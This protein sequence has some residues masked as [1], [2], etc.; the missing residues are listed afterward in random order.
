MWTFEYEHPTTAAREAVWALWSDV[1]RWPEWDDDLD[2]VSL[3]GDFSA[4]TSGT[5]T[6]KGIGPLEFTITAAEPGR[7][8]SD[9][10]LLPG[11]VLRFEH[12]LLPAE[13]GTVIRQRVT[14]DGPSANDYFAELGP[15]IILDV[16]TALAR[17]ADRAGAERAERARP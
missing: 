1:A 12:E 11:A 14:M 15:K 10:T 16:P 9:E 13:S 4:G 7:G 8:Y 17:L 6:P 2:A 3:D 5:L